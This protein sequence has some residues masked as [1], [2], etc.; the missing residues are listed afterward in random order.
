VQVKAGAV[1]FGTLF[2]P[3]AEIAFDAGSWIKGRPGRC[4]HDG[5]ARDVPL[6]RGDGVLS[7]AESAA[8]FP[9]DRDLDA[10]GALNLA[11]FLNRRTTAVHI[12]DIRGNPYQADVNYRGYTAVPLFVDTVTLNNDWHVTLSGRFNCTTLENRDRIRAGGE[13]GSLDGEHV[14]SR[15]TPRPA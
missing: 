3:L 10:S 2:A 5:R 11:D 7:G 15:L 14:F 4:D 13:A 1:I 8:H 9:S 12:N 6:A